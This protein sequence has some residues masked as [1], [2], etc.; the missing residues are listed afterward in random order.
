MGAILPR[1]EGGLPARRAERR[2]GGTYVTSGIRDRVRSG[3]QMEE[4]E[5]GKPGEIG[6]KAD[7][8]AAVFEGKG[9]D[10]GV[11]P[12]A[13]RESCSAAP[14]ADLRP[15]MW[16]VGKEIHFGEISEFL[17]SPPRFG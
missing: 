2:G 15:C 6:V 12:E 4:I 14:S 17:I 9:G 11:G 3:L 13:V 5:A 16:A 1:K 7:D 8:A 10:P